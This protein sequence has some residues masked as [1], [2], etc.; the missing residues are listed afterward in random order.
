MIARYREHEPAP[1]LR[2]YVECYWT[3]RGA[4]AGGVRRDRVLPD[5]CMDVLFNL[6][7]FPRRDGAA[8]HRHRSYVVGAMP[9]AA[10]FETAGW[11][12]LVGV[13]FRAGGAPPYLRTDAHEL[14]GVTAPLAAFWP[15]TGELEERLA[16]STGGE[17]IRL[18]DAVLLDR[19][20]DAVAGEAMDAPV[21]RVARRLERVASGPGVA[22]LAGEV[23]LSERQLRRRFRSAVGL[24]P[25]QAHR[26][27][28]FRRAVR[29]LV[30][31]TAPDPGRV[32]VRAGYYDQPHFNRD[33]KALA[34]VTP[35]E[36]LAE[37]G[38]G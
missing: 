38:V 28:R 30:E 3:I 18:L 26:I 2:P 1:Q 10:V 31:T 34:G 4:P 6:G 16:E 32:A 7:D 5:G 27:A 20:R 14:T 36:W 23:G 17:R 21:Q 29:G 9:R 8:D 33:F 37:R 22:G 24:S 19:V 11:L 35:L 13:R 25:K 12:D 15:R